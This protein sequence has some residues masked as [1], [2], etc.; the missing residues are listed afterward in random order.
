[1]TRNIGDINTNYTSTGNGDYVF[2]L[3]GWG[4]SLSVFTN[5]SEIISKGYTTV[6][7]DLPGFGDTDEPETPWDITAFAEYVVDFIKSFNCKRVIL[8]GHS[9]GGRIIIKMTSLP[10]LPFEITK[11]ILVDSAGILPRRTMKYKVRVKCYK[12]GKRVLN[13]SL[14]KKHFPNL[15]ETYAKK[16][17]SSDYGDASPIMRQSLVKLVNED[18]APLLHNITAS[19]LLIWGEN[20][21]ATP[22]SDGQLMEKLIP[23]SG[24]VVLKGAGHFSFIEQQYTF[25]R[26]VKSF[27][28]MDN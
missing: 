19:V 6:C 7:L 4:S 25:N 22:L 27:L 1:M 12:F 11:I 28:G 23:G 9:N 18:L 15:I 17:G 10:N 14:L 8:L 2:L 21:T 5:I 13:M 20:D 24:L 16:L 3:H 26:V